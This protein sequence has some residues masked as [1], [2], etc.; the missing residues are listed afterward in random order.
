MA[1]RATGRRKGDGMIKRLLERMRLPRLGVIRLGAK[2]SNKSG[3]GE[4]PIELPY[5]VVPDDLKG[6][7]EPRPTRLPVLFPSDEPERV[8]VADYIRYQGKLLTLKCDGEIFHEIAPNGV[9][10]TGRC[11]KVGREKC[12]CGAEAKARLN[13]II[14]DGPL[15]IYQVLI[16]GEQRI[17]DLLSELL[18]FR[19]TL[20]RLTEILFYLERVP[21]EIQIKK[22]D[23]SRLARTGWPVHI[24]CDFTAKQ[25]LRA[26]GLTVLGAGEP[27]AALPAREEEEA[28]AVHEG[29]EDEPA[30][31]P[32]DSAPRA[33]SGL[34]PAESVETGPAR[35]EPPVEEWTIERVVGRATVLG[36]GPGTFKNYCALRFRG[37]VLDDLGAAELQRLGQEMTA[38]EAGGSKA[39]A[40]WKLRI[41]TALKEAAQAKRR[42]VTG[43]TR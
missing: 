9:E 4:H 36:V 17:A 13:V 43:A 40:D 6:L 28:E 18:I 15:G 21:T 11:R 39:K 19:Q 5:F 42:A 38:A 14:L 23:G 22:E 41:L 1:R 35:L 3:P 7:L 31:R 12:P 30:A 20:G 34:P 24:R 8:L 32:T 25:A 29:P 26:R 33:D 37:M 27:L 10:S 2:V 16:G